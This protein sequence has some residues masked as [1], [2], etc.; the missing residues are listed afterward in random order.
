MIETTLNSTDLI[1]KGLN[2]LSSKDK[3]LAKLVNSNFIFSF[4][5]KETGFSALLKII[6]SQQLSTSAANNI[7]NRFVDSNLITKSKILSVNDQTLCSLGLSRQK[8]SYIKGLAN[9]DINYDDLSNMSS[10]QII[11]RLTKIKGIG[12]WTAEIYCLFTLGQANIFPA[13]DLAL[14]E[15]IKIVFGFQKRPTEKEVLELSMNWH[16][17]KSL[18]AHLLWDY[19]RKMKNKD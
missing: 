6:I 9:E 3:N 1:N 4:Q 2:F 10:L 17:W 12:K 19:Y 15:A 7:W 16:P 11:N 5:K 8:C 18:A 14:Q 13:G